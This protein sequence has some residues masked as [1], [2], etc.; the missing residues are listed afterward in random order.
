MLPV[1]TASGVVNIFDHDPDGARAKGQLFC[2]LRLVHCV[3]DTPMKVL[4]VH[5]DF[6]N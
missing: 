5:V 2:V 4:I 6:I 3:P 1:A